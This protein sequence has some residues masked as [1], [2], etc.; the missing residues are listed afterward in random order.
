MSSCATTPRSSDPRRRRKRDVPLGGADRVEALRR[1]KIIHTAD[2]VE[3]LRREKIIHTYTFLLSTAIGYARDRVGDAIQ[4][5]RKDALVL[6]PAR[7]A[8][9]ISGWHAPDLCGPSC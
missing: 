6:S 8:L 2:R 4:C 9:V 3:A 1:E 5:R 7:L